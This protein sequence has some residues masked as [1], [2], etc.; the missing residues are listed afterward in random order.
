MR[1]P[2]IGTAR[3]PYPEIPLAVRMGIERALRWA[4]EELRREPNGTAPDPRAAS[5]DEITEYLQRRLNTLERGKPVVCRF[6]ASLLES[7]QRGG[8]YKNY[9]GSSI[10]RA[11]DLVFRP[12]IIPPGVAVTTDYAFF[13]ECK[14]VGGSFPV[15]RYLANG[16]RRFVAGDYAWAMRSALMVAYARDGAEVA[17]ALAIRL[18]DRRYRTRARPAPRPDDDGALPRTLISVHARP[19]KHPP[20]GQKLGDIEVAHLWLPVG[21]AAGERVA[22]GKRCR[23]RR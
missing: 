2:W 16:L 23:R 21:P 11:P 10:K 15:A 3:L 4:W 17:T 20:S 5:E 13:V 1:A 9:S 7:V 19:L 8:N 18:K 12:A 22:V 6:A 14:I